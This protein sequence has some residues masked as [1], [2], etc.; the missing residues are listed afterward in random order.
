MTAGRVLAF[1][2][3]LALCALFLAF[4][5]YA[6]GLALEDFEAGRVGLALLWGA[7]WL[8]GVLALAD[9]AKRAAQVWK[10]AKEEKT[11]QP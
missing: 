3:W 7:F 6:A 10:T 4:A 8:V 5:A 1:A 2:L 11:G 9:S